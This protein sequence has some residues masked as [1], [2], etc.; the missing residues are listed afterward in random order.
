MNWRIKAFMADVEKVYTPIDKT[1]K[2]EEEIKEIEKEYFWLSLKLQFTAGFILA[3][4]IWFCYFSYI[5][6]R[7]IITNFY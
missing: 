2:T 1:N 3:C 5:I 4:A 6:I 7:F